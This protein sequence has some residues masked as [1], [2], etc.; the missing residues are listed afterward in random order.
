MRSVKVLGC[1][2]QHN[3][4]LVSS[5]LKNGGWVYRG[6]THFR[7]SRLY[8]IS[9]LR[10]KEF[11]SISMSTFLRMT[12]HS[13]WHLTCFK[14]KCSFHAD[15][16]FRLFQSYPFLISHKIKSGKYLDD[17]DLLSSLLSMPHWCKMELF[18]KIIEIKIQFCNRDRICF[19]ATLCAKNLTKFSE[20]MWTFPSVCI[21]IFPLLCKNCLY[22][23][24]CQLSMKTLSAKILRHKF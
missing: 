13:F 11:S 12:V 1:Q 14:L 6:Y 7:C 3:F 22:R 8:C 20:I 23:L 16:L 24:K 4:S 17:L 5:K 9:L 2:K 19:H 18:F 10:R 21:C 15:V